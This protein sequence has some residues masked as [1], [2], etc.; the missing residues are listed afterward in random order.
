MGYDKGYSDSGKD[1]LSTGSFDW[2]TGRL[3]IVSV[4]EGSNGIP[5][6]IETQFLMDPTKEYVAW[7]ID[8]CG[9]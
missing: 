1:G 8:G 2:L 4:S 7:G 5:Y 3:Y 6:Q 9:S